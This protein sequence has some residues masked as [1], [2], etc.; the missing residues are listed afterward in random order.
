MHAGTQSP[1]GEF[2]FWNFDFFAQDSWKLKPNFT[3]EYGVR[4]GY[5]TNNGELNG[6]GG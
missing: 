2:R 3:L 1:D 4:A 5:W 6:L